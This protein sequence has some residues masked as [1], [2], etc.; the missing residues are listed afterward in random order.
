MKL[1]KS[2]MK[3]IHSSL[4]LKSILCRSIKNSQKKRDGRS[5]LSP[6]LLK[7]RKERGFEP[8]L[9]SKKPKKPVLLNLS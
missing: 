4:K 1:R 5:S 7:D 8:K 2:F 3:N 9:R 6:K